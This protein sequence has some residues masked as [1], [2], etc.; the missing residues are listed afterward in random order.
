[1][2]SERPQTCV[3]DALLFP[4]NN[5]VI[6]TTPSTSHLRDSWN[7][8]EGRK[9]LLGI[10]EVGK[11]QLRSHLLLLCNILPRATDHGKGTS[12]FLCPLALVSIKTNF[13][14]SSFKLSRQKGKGIS[15][16]ILVL[17]LYFSVLFK[18]FLKLS[19][20]FPYSVGLTVAKL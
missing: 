20:C 7:G 16:A 13:F 1:M 17:Y 10:E 2:G 5:H 11:S 18:I 9:V 12:F 6:Q 15:G 4:L 19:V 8:V 14:D 3:E